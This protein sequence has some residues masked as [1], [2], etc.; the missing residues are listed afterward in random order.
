VLEGGG[1]DCAPRGCVV[2]DGFVGESRGGGEEANAR[3][4]CEREKIGRGRASCEVISPV[5]KWD[6]DTL[7]VL[8][9]RS[10]GCVN[11]T[12]EAEGIIC[13]VVNDVDERT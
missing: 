10:A 2:N 8:G 6:T 4:R 9:L 13:K 1:R 11:G 3:R 12:R 5:S 7:L